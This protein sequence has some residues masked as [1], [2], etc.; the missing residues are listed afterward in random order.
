MAAIELERI[1]EVIEALAGHLVAAV[2]NPAVGLQQDGGAKIAIG[3][4]PIA[5]AA[6]LATEAQNTLI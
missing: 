4:P 5:G 2:D 6:G 3:V 1:L